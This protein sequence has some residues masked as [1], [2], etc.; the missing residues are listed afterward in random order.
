MTREER[1][2]LFFCLISL[3]AATVLSLD[4]ILWALH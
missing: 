4:A 3:G 1:F 2:L